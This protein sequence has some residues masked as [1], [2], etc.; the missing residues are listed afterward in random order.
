MTFC[1]GFIV[2][3][4]HKLLGFIFL[5]LEEGDVIEE[6]FGFIGEREVGLHIEDGR[7]GH[8]FALLLC[9]LQGSPLHVFIT[10]NQHHSIHYVSFISVLLNF[11]PPGRSIHICLV[12]DEISW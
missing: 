4:H 10:G 3:L 1:H 9:S 8:F 11:P 5:Q 2:V 7:L 12:Q 6:C